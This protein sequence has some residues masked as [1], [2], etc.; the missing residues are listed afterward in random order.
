MND[1]PRRTFR[2][3][4]LVF[5]PANTS[6]PSADEAIILVMPADPEPQ[7]IVLVLH[8]K[9][10]MVRTDARGPEAA[11]LLEVERWMPRITLEQR[12]RS[13][14]KLPH[15]RR[16]LVVR[17]PEPRV[18]SVLQS[19]RVRPA[20]RSAMASSASA[21]RRPAATSAS[22][23]RSQAAASNSRNHRRNSES[24]SELNPLTAR[25]ISLMVDI[26][27][28]L[29]GSAVPINSPLSRCPRRRF[30]QGCDCRL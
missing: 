19:G 24:S 2:P 1:E 28:N 4:G 30:E 9:G 5:F 23:S 18:G 17:L 29:S 27:S 21:S 25:S 26:P 16:K 12:K 20:R 13:I 14:G 10:P 11:D 22:K 3:A 8:R 7:K 6:L 15:L